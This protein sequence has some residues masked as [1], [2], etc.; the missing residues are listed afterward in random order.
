[1]A[2]EFACSG[3]GRIMR[4]PDAAAGRKARCPLCGTVQD[5]PSGSGRDSPFPPAAAG[6]AEPP[7]AP[8]V[9]AAAGPS[10]M[11]RDCLK[12]IFYGVSNLDSIFK[13]SLYGMGL[14]LVLQLSLTFLGTFL[15]ANRGGNIVLGGLGV[16]VWLILGGFYLRF[17]LDAVISSLEGCDQAPP[18]PSFDVPEMI[19]AGLKG[20]AVLAVYVLPIVTL[21]LLP[22]GLLAWGYTNDMRTFDLAWA[23]KAAARRPGHLVLLWPVLL[24]WAVAGM[25]A[26]LLIWLLVAP[27]AGGLAAMG[28][29]GLLASLVV[30]AVGSAVITAVGI[31]FTTV[32]FRCIGMLGRYNPILTEMLPERAKPIRTGV[33]IAVGVLATAA[34]W[35]VLVPAALSG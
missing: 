10:Q 32:Q 29:F 35:L 26:T 14:A 24:V 13:L 19:A 28:C 31:M 5:I 12:A 1:M 17:L 25:V 3:C 2:I 34:I 11:L 4:A 22:L 15:L 16:V 9:A 18:V 33:F 23:A 20:T 27:I 30:L 21:P 6:P 7:Q 8:A